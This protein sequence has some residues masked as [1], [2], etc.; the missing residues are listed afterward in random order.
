VTEQWDFV[1]AAYGLTALMTAAV[2]VNSWWAMRTAEK[3]ADKLR[4]DRP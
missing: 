2:L 1:I 3:R 4:Q